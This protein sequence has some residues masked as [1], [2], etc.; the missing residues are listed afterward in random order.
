M[1]LSNEEIVEELDRFNKQSKALKKNIIKMCWYM[2]GGITLDEL[3]QLG[4][5]D[6]EIIN[7]VI[8]DNLDVTKESGL[9]F[10]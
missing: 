1:T 6:R 5:D 2:R 4:F 3:Y 8:E 9:P 10:F 7:K